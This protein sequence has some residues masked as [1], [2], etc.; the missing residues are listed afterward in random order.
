MQEIIWMPG[1]APASTRPRSGRDWLSRALLATGGHF[2]RWAWRLAPRPAVAPAVVSVEFCRE[3][4]GTEGA[5]YVDGHL[6]GTLA[7][8]Q[9]L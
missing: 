9:R 4:G 3:V 2:I 6:L 5:V 7:G 8:V 1:R